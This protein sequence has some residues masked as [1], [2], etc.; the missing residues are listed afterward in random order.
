M[1]KKV[2]VKLG[3]AVLIATAALFG[4]GPAPA[5]ALSCPSGYG[6]CVY[7]SQS[8]DGSECCCYYTDVNNP[9]QICPDFCS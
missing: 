9:E 6:S 3:L 8:C 1:Q 4:M 5:R 2:L 7:D